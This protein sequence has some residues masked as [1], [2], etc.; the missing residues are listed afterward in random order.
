VGFLSGTSLDRGQ[1]AFNLTANN[2][3]TLP[4]GWLAELNGQYQSNETYGF[5]VVQQRGQVAVGLQKS[6]LDKQATLRL[7][8]ADI[9]YTTPVYSTATYDGFAESFRSAQDTRVVTLAFTYRFGS[10]Q[11][12]AARRRAAGAEEELRR[13][14]GQ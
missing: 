4:G 8:A 6:L 1:P 9:F 10:A 5:E 12:A 2:T 14:G 3:F 7:S 11:V 13:A